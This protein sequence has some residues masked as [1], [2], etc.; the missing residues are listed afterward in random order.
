MWEKTK[1]KHEEETSA[2][3]HIH[4][5]YKS[6]WNRFSLWLNF[7]FVPSLTHTRTLA[8]FQCQPN[9]AELVLLCFFLCTKFNIGC[10]RERRRRSCVYVRC[11]WGDGCVF[12]YK[13]FLFLALALATP[14][15]TP[16]PSN[17]LSLSL[18][19]HSAACHKRN[20]KWGISA[21]YVYLCRYNTTKET[22]DTF[23]SN[24]MA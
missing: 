13:M 22:Y 24:V 6:H 3:H 11:V 15:Q 10:K 5:T 19:P 7:P 8:R 21:W 17:S 4:N 2:W 20:S 16:T 1:K 9:N 18:C 14:N 23:F 12:A